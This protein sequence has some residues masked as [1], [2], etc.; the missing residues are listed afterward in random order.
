[1][2]TTGEGRYILADEVV[3]MTTLGHL[4]RSIELGNEAETISCFDRE[5]SYRSAGTRAQMQRLL[6]LVVRWQVITPG[7]PGVINRDNG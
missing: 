4:E 2:Y 7:C 1:M 3:W 5:A 6:E